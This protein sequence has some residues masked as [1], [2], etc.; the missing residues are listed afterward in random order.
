MCHLSPWSTYIMYLKM[1]NE[2][3][4]PIFFVV[5]FT[6]YQL[7]SI[8]STSSG[9]SWL[10]FMVLYFYF[11]LAQNKS[12]KL[13]FATINTIKYFRATETVSKNVRETNFV[14]YTKF[15]IYIKKPLCRKHGPTQVS[16]CSINIR[17]INVRICM[18]Q[19]YIQHN[20]Q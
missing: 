9:T 8:I 4:F 6:M 3:I 12:L 18:Q 2:R 20:T 13:N 11:K 16:L 1:K 7:V 5:V 14:P 19:P 17:E 10:N 15:K